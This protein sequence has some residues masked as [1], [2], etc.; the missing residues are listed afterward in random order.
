VNQEAGSAPDAAFA[1]DDQSG[2]GMLEQVEIAVRIHR[3]HA[4]FRNVLPW[5]SETLRSAFDGLSNVDRVT[6]S[7]PLA[8]TMS[9]VFGAVTGIWDALFHERRPCRLGLAIRIP[10]SGLG[11]KDGGIAVPLFENVTS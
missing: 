10:D 4:D 9:G 8:L 11:T 1:I 2:H 6:T 3:R 7:T 5:A